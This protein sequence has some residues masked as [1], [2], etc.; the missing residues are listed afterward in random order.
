MEW[1]KIV[2]DFL[3]DNYPKLTP[4]NLSSILNRSVGSINVKLK[5]LGIRG[6]INKKYNKFVFDL[7]NKHHLYIMG[8]LWADGYIH[9]N[10][11][12]LELSIL[13]DDFI[14]ISQ[15]FDNKFW[16][17]Y[18]RNRKNRKSQTTI[19][20]Y[21]K[22]VCDLFRNKYN[23]Q[24]KSIECPN[25]INEIDDK[26]L[27]YFVR[28]YFDG[29]GCFYISKDFK[30]RQCYLCGDFNQDWFWIEEIFKKFD[31]EYT[32]KRKSQTT[33][34]YSIVYIKRKS[35]DIFGKYIYNGYLDDKIGIKRKYYKFI[36][37]NEKSN[38]NISSLEINR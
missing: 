2:I 26:L 28:G 17:I 15:L 4:N 31:I 14:D 22:D 20:L 18:N 8:F 23:Y 29:D 32:I 33:G 37:H 16:A 12:R 36:N 19:G 5:H 24:N 38:C 30:Q 21:R 35:I 9:K 34:R 10:L 7:Q 13:T 11:N 6:G 27:H 1:D 25:F 3:V